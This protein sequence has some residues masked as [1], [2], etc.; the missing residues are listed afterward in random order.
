MST[1]ALKVPQDGRVTV[2]TGCGS[3]EQDYEDGILERVMI[4]EGETRAF[5]ARGRVY[6]VRK[7]SPDRWLYTFKFWAVGPAL[8]SWAV[9]A[10]AVDIA[11]RNGDVD[12][13]VRAWRCYG[14]SAEIGDNRLVTLTFESERDLTEDVADQPTT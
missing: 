5:R 1:E 12:W 9:P 8:T 13:T 3:L 2:L 10:Q 6:S 7:I 14:F 11:W 4:A